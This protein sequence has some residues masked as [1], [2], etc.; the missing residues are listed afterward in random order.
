MD[1]KFWL[2][3]LAI[4][5]CHILIIGSKYELTRMFIALHFPISLVFEGFIA[6]LLF[7]YVRKTLSTPFDID[8][9]LRKEETKAK[10]LSQGPVRSKEAIRKYRIQGM[11]TGAGLAV[12]VYVYHSFLLP[13]L[14]F[15]QSAIPPERRFEFYPAMLLPALVAVIGVPLIEEYY[16]RGL[17][18]S[19]I[20]YQT[21]EKEESPGIKKRPP[22]VWVA[23]AISLIAFV[24]VHD[25]VVAP[26]M[27]P[28]GIAFGLLYL[29]GGLNSSIFAHATYNLLILLSGFLPFP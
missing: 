22:Q 23:F 29:K 16:F 15:E 14:P 21:S 5:A 7:K 11:L 13:F 8:T 17:L 6:T 3:C 1:R 20:S 18:I 4:I 25:K 24:L 27:V 26:V 10:L 12:A 19:S 9:G 2:L 28:V